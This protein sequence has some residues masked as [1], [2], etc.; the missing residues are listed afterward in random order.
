MMVAVAVGT[1]MIPADALL[2]VTVNARSALWTE[3]SAALM[4]NAFIVS[5]SAKLTVPESAV[6]AAKSDTVAGLAPEPAMA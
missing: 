1:S 2:S 3:S 4:V 6:P 5:P